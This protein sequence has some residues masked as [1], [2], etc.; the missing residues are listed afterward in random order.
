MSWEKPRSY[1]SFDYYHGEVPTEAARTV[2]GKRRLGSYS[3]LRLHMLFATLN[4]DDPEEILR[5]VEQFGP[6]FVLPYFGAPPRHLSET[7]T[8]E[9]EELSC[10]LDLDEAAAGVWLFRWVADLAVAYLAAGARRLRELLDRGYAVTGERGWT[11]KYFFG[12]LSV[13]N[14]EP[15]FVRGS[16]MWPPC[17]AGTDAFREAAD[18]LDCVFYMVLDHVHP[19]LQVGTDEE[20]M[21]ARGKEVLDAPFSLLL[22]WEFSKTILYSALWLMLLL[23]ITGAKTL[24]RCANELCARLF[25][26]NRSDKEHCCLKCQNRAKQRRHKERAKSLRG[27]WKRPKVPRG[28]LAARWKATS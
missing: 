27:G 19:M 14:P 1:R 10:F 11:E 13:R 8:R 21:R 2:L 6:P 26:A 25:L 7:L 22:G 28:Q 12:I 23:D 4:P 9:G 20:V 17:P 24:R 3:G 16:Q 5:F 18:V 15:A